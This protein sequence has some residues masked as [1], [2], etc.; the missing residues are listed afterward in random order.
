MQE[1][2]HFLSFQ[3]LNS[4]PILRYLA[5]GFT[6]VTEASFQVLS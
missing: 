6:E 3:T 2:L 5:F 1:I 4:L